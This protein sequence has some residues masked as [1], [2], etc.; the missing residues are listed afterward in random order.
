M[1]LFGELTSEGLTELE[2]S[3]GAVPTQHLHTLFHVARAS[4][5]ILSGIEDAV[6]AS[7]LSPAQFRLLMALNF[8]FSGTGRTTE[9]ADTLGVRPPTLS[10]LLDGSSELVRRDRRS[11]DRRVIWLS[12]TSRGHEILQKTLPA[13]QLV[14]QRLD[15]ALGHQG[16]QLI[17]LLHTAA[18][19]TRSQDRAHD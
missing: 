18:T 17:R 10:Q 6:K 13:V 5:E 16:D 2:S 8:Q 14:A 3:V 15:K 11:P 4:H 1:F 19:A 7:G 12:L 9:V